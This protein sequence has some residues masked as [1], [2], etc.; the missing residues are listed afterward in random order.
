[1]TSY[2]SQAAWERWRSAFGLV[3]ERLAGREEAISNE[4]ISTWPIDLWLGI[5][6]K[7]L[8]QK[9]LLFLSGFASLL[10]LRR[11]FHLPKHFFLFSLCACSLDSH[12]QAVDDSSPN[13]RG[14]RRRA[15]EAAPQRRV[16]C[17]PR[18]EARAGQTA[19]VVHAQEAR[20]AKWRVLRA[21]EARAGHAACAVRAVCGGG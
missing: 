6:K 16:Q 19:C 8:P 11:L 1:M 15:R 2:L 9:P 12:K 13:L 18:Q 7:M 14:G 5:I 21:Q 20:A 3:G 10:A 4:E 17:V